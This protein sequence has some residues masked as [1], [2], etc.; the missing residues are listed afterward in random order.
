MG[1]T[2]QLLIHFYKIKNPSQGDGFLKYNT[3]F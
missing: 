2:K 3:K 1:F